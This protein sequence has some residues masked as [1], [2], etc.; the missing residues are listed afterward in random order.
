VT[1]P[2]EVARIVWL[3]MLVAVG[4][5][6]VVLAVLLGQDGTP[7]DVT[8][9]RRVFMGLAFGDFVVIYALRQR[10]PLDAR[11]AGDAQAVLTTY[12]MCWALSEAVALFGLVLGI[13]GRSFDEAA[14]F[15]IV[16][17]ALLL[18]Q[19]PRAAHFAS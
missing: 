2:F 7:G 5:Y 11:P 18:W 15:F 3:A 10:L 12:I 16:A 6:A 13:L 1:R 14:P 8:A 17:A 4:L 19:R 9:L